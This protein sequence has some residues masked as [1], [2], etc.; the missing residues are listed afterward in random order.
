MGDGSID[1]ILIIYG[2]VLEVLGPVSP[3]HS[4]V[5]N[6]IVILFQL[7]LKSNNVQHILMYSSDKV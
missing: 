2:T 7:S 6:F 1:D 5:Q 3:C 4:L